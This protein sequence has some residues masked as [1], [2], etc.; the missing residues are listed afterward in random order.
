MAG[1]QEAVKQIDCTITNVNSHSLGVQGLE[2][3]TGRRIN[4]VLIP[5]NT[6]LP[7]RVTKKFVT[8]KADQR[9]LAVNILEGESRMPTA[10]TVVG[11]TIVRN[12]PPQLPQG[13]PVKITF[14]YAINGCLQVFVS[15]PGT[16]CQT[17]L[18]LESTGNR[19]EG[20]VAR[21][22]QVLADHAGLPA[23]AATA[24]SELGTQADPR[25]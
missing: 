15:V 11:T 24:L 18:E 8:T 16:D 7:A 12:L 9:S 14:A 20:Q 21:W 10:C 23:V 19:D 6:P 25:R 13:T 22:R 3:E 1:K 4:R 17:R 5:K 2:V